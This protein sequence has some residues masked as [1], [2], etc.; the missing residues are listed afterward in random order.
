MP[1]KLITIKQ[2][3]I[4]MTARKVSCTQL[5]AAAKAGISER[6][7]RELENG[8]RKSG[9]MVR[10]WQTRDDHNGIMMPDTS[11]IGHLLGAHC[12]PSCLAKSAGQFTR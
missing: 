1:G 12:R 3:E 5:L 6:S 7:G 10:R 4:Y 9:D 2:V 11:G 8:G